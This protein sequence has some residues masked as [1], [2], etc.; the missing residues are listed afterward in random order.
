M[1]KTKFRIFSKLSWPNLMESTL[2]SL[3]CSKSKP[4][5]RMERSIQRKWLHMT[6]SLVTDLSL[7][8]LRMVLAVTA[9]VK[10]FE[11]STSLRLLFFRS[12]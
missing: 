4:R 1:L 11:M 3:F 5:K 6:C 8:K 7:E 10:Q 12:L 9:E 2:T